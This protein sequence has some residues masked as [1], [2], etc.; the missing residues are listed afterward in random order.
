MAL[1]LPEQVVAALHGW[2]LESLRG[3]RVLSPEAMHVTL[4]FLGERPDDEIDAIGEAAMA[5]ARPVHGLQPRRPAALGR[6]RALSIDLAD[7][8]GECASLQQAVGDALAAIGAYEP[9]Q[10]AFRPHVTVAR[11]HGVKA[12]GLPP[13]PPIDAFD[14]R[15]LTLFQSHLGRGGARYEALVSAPLHVLD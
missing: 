8:H 15:A 6:G 11:G 4:A 7:P 12:H 14:G 9:E 13:L 2:A 1:E 5:C 10:R 3:L